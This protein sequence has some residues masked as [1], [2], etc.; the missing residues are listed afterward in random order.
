MFGYSMAWKRYYVNDACL[1][2]SH[3]KY[4]FAEKDSHSGFCK[5]VFIA[6]LSIIQW[7]LECFHGDPSSIGYM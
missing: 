4:N 3:M 7:H 6:S 2:Q 1:G 5:S